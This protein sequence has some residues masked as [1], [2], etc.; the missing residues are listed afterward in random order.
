LFI[1]RS[2]EAGASD[3]IVGFGG[4]DLMFF[5]S[6]DQKL[7]F[8][9]DGSGSEDAVLIAAFVDSVSL[10]AEDLCIFG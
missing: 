2:A 9:A 8:D 6:R 5:D 4:Y 10:R 7:W 1:Y 3:K